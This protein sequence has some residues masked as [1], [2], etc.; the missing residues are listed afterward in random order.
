MA[1]HLIETHFNA[2]ESIISQ[3]ET[4]YEGGWEGLVGQS[5]AIPPIQLEINCN[6]KN[7]HLMMKIRR[8]GEGGTMVNKS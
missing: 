1:L 2:T 5:W 6:E 7:G 8:G 3:A 4:R